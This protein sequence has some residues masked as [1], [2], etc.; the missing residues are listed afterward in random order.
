MLDY[1]LETTLWYDL[2]SPAADID[3]GMIYYYLQIKIKER[4]DE[5]VN[6]DMVLLWP[7][8]P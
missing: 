6:K 2:A 5:F 3:F 1:D 4:C 8:W 7:Q